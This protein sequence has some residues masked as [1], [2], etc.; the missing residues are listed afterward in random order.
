MTRVK[1]CGITRLTDA[2]LAV[3][4]GAWAVGFIFYKNSPRYISP[5]NAKKI[6][7]KLPPFVSLVGVFVNEREATVKKTALSCG[8]TTLQF[9]GD[10]TSAYCRKFGCWKVIKAIRVKS[11]ISPAQLKK[12]SADAFLFD[13]FIPDGYGGSGKT[14]NWSYLKSLTKFS[15][16]I[17][18]SGGLNPRNI[19]K[20]VKTV[21]PFAVDVSSGVESA[22]GR[23][24]PAKLKSLFHALP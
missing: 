7:E 9:H 16:P 19:A 20:A 8:L 22:P 11:N 10:E 18:L 6:I 21:S 15:T 4:L 2:L 3:E 13:T 1:I 5:E 14:F 24:S 23:K 17:I 12:F